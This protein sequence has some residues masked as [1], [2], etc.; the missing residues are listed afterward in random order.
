LSGG[1]LLV[2][3][4]FNQLFVTGHHPVERPTGLHELATSLAHRFGA[5]RVAENVE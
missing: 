1:T 2:V 3:E 5:V 4:H